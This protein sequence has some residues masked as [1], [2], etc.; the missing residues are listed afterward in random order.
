M[1]FVGE[2]PEIEAPTRLVDTEAMS[3]EAGASA[4]S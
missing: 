1:W 4:S 3:N 2:F